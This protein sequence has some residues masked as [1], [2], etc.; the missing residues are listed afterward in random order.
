MDLKTLQGEWQPAGR[1]GRYPGIIAITDPSLEP[2]GRFAASLSGT[3]TTSG[4]RRVY[5]AL[6]C[7]DGPVVGI[8]YVRRCGLP[9]TSASHW[10]SA[11]LQHHQKV[12]SKQRAIRA[13]S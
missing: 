1:A 11:Q 9:P 6:V 3:P 5:M 8:S 2:D 4:S 12:T 10:D 7:T 13:A